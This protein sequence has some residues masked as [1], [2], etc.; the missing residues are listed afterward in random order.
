MQSALSHRTKRDLFSN[1]YLD[2]HLPKQS[3][4][5]EVDEEMVEEAKGE[6]VEDLE[7]S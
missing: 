1:C 4:W 6:V 5:D 7:R 3:A 2:E